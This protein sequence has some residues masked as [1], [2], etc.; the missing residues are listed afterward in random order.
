MFDSNVW[1]EFHNNDL[2]LS[3]LARLVEDQHV[4]V[5][6][7]SIQEQETFKS[8][9]DS[10]FGHYKRALRA[11]TIESEGIILGFGRLDFDKFGTA[12]SKF[13]VQGGSHNSDE[14]I[15]ETTALNNAWL[16]T[17]EK[18]RLRTLAIRNKLPVFNLSELLEELSK[19]GLLP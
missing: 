7:T 19:R 16:V 11:Q 3:K 12:E 10:D 17:Q 4:K 13:V 9:K 18:K 8:A 6:T 14:V 15:A 1:D 2:A 5:L